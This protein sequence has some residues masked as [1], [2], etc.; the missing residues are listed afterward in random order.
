MKVFNGLFKDVLESCA[1]DL[2]TQCQAEAATLSPS[3]GV[4]CL[5]KHYSIVSS[6]CRAQL[7]S[8]ASYA[9][10]CGTEAAQYCSDKNNPQDIFNC[11]SAVIKVHPT[12]DFDPVCNN[13]IRGYQNCLPK[14][15]KG[16][17]KNNDGSSL[18]NIVTFEDDDDADGS[19]NNNFDGNLPIEYDEEE[20][21]NTDNDDDTIGSWFS[22]NGDDHDDSLTDDNTSYDYNGFND[23]DYNDEY[24]PT[25]QPKL[26]P[27]PKP[28]GKPNPNG[29]GGGKSKPQQSSNMK[30]QEKPKK[31]VMKVL[32]TGTKESNIMINER[33]LQGGGSKSKPKPKPS[34]NGGGNGGDLPPP[35]GGKPCW[36][37]DDNVN[38]GEKN[39]NDDNINYNSI[40]VERGGL[41]AFIGLVFSLVILGVMIYLWCKNG[42]SFANLTVQRAAE[43]V[44]EKD[45]YEAG[46][47]PTAADDHDDE[48]PNNR[49]LEPDSD[50]GAI[51]MSDLN[52]SSS[53][54]SKLNND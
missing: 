30:M 50:N 10:P 43:I 40:N 14:S 27:K 47:A 4:S 26:K 25:S 39:I 6:S 51:E 13:A 2:L 29:G 23:D 8:L 5:F 44:T 46:Y 49:M 33:K 38:A 28:K 48:G 41:I 12:E 21:N 24:A 17:F 16:D 11:L 32:I 52:V 20:N 18:N 1:L 36:V 7:D 3:E 37:V 9:V 19:Y 35:T 45:P 31:P 54:Y 53:G 34:P 42:R 22:N 15:D